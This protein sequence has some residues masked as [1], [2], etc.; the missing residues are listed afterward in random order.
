MIRRAEYEDIPGIMEFIDR[1]WKKNH[2][3][4]RERTLFE[5]QHQWGDETAYIIS[6]SEDRQINGVLGYIPYDR[7]DRDVMLAIWKT[8]KTDDTMLGI[9]MLELLRNTPGNRSVSAPGINPDTRSI[10]HFLGI[11][12]GMMK[13]WYRLR[14]LEEYHIALVKEHTIPEY[15]KA[16]CTVEEYKE[17][18]KLADSFR[19][20]D[21]LCRAGHPYKS[22][23]Y[24]KRRYYEHP[25]F[26]YLKYGLRK[27]DKKLLVILRVQKCNGSAALRLVDGIGD[28][29]LLRYFTPMLDRLMEIYQCE[30][31]DLYEC[32][33]ED[34]ILKDGG[35]TRTKETGNIIP[36][37]FSPFEQQNVDIYYMSSIP[38]AVLFKADGDTDR[39]N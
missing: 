36:E 37:Y 2:I 8:I 26:R 25:V 33:V 14:K 35:W 3:L 23:Q 5:F 27:D 29:G 21:C 28:E 12:T 22:M 16:G 30:Y 38:G 13:Q 34:E 17:F 7:K 10:Y 11:K 32:G 20:E 4:S 39:P 19:I 6:E 24:L 18:E 15:K 31:A 1:Y 9:K